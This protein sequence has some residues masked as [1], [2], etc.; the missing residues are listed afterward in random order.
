MSKCLN[1]EEIKM[2]DEAYEK[3]FNIFCQSHQKQGMSEKLSQCR[4][5]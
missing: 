3:V 2:L 1:K 5:V 4:R